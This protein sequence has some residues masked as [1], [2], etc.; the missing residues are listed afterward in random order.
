MYYISNNGCGSSWCVGGAGCSRRHVFGPSGQVGQYVGTFVRLFETEVYLIFTKYY[1]NLNWYCIVCYIIFYI[2]W[3][4]N[5]YYRMEEEGQHGHRSSNSQRR[6]RWR[7]KGW[8]EFVGVT[9]KTTI[10]MGSWKVTGAAREKRIPA[11]EFW[12]EYRVRGS[13]V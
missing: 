2:C 9:I 12:E 3:D 8:N 5:V 13:N 1:V 10:K 4:C 7:E 6:R 11:L